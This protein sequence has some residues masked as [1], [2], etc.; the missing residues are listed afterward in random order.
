M[1]ARLRSRL[2][3]P[4]HPL[5]TGQAPLTTA[6]AAA[7]RRELPAGGW[8]WNKK[9]AHGPPITALVAATPAHFGLLSTPAPQPKRRSLP[10]LSDTGS[11]GHREEP[12]RDLDK[13]PV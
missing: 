1:S 8:A 3:H 6:V 10:P 9:T 7:G 5:R 13:I 2:L 4:V 11:G 12:F